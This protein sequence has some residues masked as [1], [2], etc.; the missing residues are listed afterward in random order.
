M[1]ELSGTALV[2]AKN[3]TMK[4]T[5]KS[6][7]ITFPSYEVKGGPLRSINPLDKCMEAAS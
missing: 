1:V 7:W 6:V 4:H 3:R 5:I 2:F